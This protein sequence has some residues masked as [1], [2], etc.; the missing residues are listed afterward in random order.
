MTYRGCSF[1][2][3]APWA[4]NHVLSEGNLGLHLPLPVIRTTSV[5][6]TVDD[7]QLV[8]LSLLADEAELVEGDGIAVSDH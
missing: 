4:L 5:V 6:D 8:L 1:Q 7:G 3:A 2:G